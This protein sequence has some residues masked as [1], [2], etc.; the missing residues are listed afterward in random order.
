MR[1]FVLTLEGEAQTWYKSLMDASIDV[2]DLFQQNFT[3]I[4]ANKPDNSSLINSFTHIKNNGDETITDF[5]AC[6]SK[7]YYKFP[8][9][10]RPNDN[11]A[12]IC[13]LEEFDGIL[14]IFLRN[15]EP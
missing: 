1:M 6:F 5:N 7:N 3:K 4:W 8:I 13:Y 15:K 2:W 10:V 14:G 11:C 12:L 9:T